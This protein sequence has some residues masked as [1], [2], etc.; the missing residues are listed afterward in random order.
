M[1]FFQK[2]EQV[3][4]HT[5]S[6]LVTYYFLSFLQDAEIAKKVEQT[7]PKKLK[8]EAKR[9]QQLVCFCYQSQQG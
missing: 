5:E 1:Y 2:Q 8:F 4:L 7:I 3:V 6:T 9:Y